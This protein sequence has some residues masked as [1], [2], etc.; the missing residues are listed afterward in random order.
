MLKFRDFAI[1]SKMG[2]LVLA[3]FCASQAHA[4]EYKLA[5]SLPATERQAVKN[6]LLKAQS[7][8]PET[9]QQ[10]LEEVTVKIEP[11]KG[12]DGRAIGVSS[13]RARSITL[14]PSIMPALLAGPEKS[15]LT[16][17]THKTAYQ[18]ALVT[19]LHETTHLYDYVNVHSQEEW[20][21]IRECDRTF[22]QSKDDRMR[23]R[24]PEC[25]F[26]ERMHT[27]LSANPYFLQIA[28]W[29]GMSDNGFSG[30]SPDAYELTDPKEYLAV[31]MEYFLLDSQYKCRRPGMYHFL[32]THFKHVPFA[33]VTCDQQLGY[34]VP[35]S[36]YKMAQMLNIDPA[37]VYQVHYLFAE[38]GEKVMSGWGHAM[39]RLV[40]CSPQRKEVGPDC[41]RDIESHLVLSF[42]AFVDSMSISTWAGLSGKYPSRLFILPM[43]QVID[44]YTKGEFRPLRSLPLKLSREQIT[45]VLTRSVEVHWSY[46]GK[47]YFVSNNCATEAFNLLQSSLLLPQIMFSEIKTPV[48]LYDLLIK[49][50]LADEN[51]L[52]DRQKAIQLGYYFDS[53]KERYNTTFA[54][55]KK[56]LPKMPAQNF[57]EYLN[58]SAARRAFMIRG[59]QAETP[60]RVQAVAA[61]YLLEI[62][63]ERRLQSA[64][65]SDLQSSLME[66]IN[67]ANKGEKRSNNAEGT[68]VDNY[69]ELSQL[70]AKASSFLPKNSGYGLPDK[71]ELAQAQAGIEQK[72]QHA[73]ETAAQTQKL[74]KELTSDELLKEADLIKA[75]IELLKKL[76]KGN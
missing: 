57:E 11:I 3:L 61:L 67:A 72:A 44:E 8:L 45:N 31:N 73:S 5:T 19:V 55:A 48:S 66:E 38:K 35:N 46:E 42:R 29:M 7:L 74:T 59:I 52:K 75:N 50:N 6:L 27:S 17:R 34:V 53:F 23:Q 10:A 64:M 16:G 14:A 56:A 2:L 49:K 22:E 1:R 30:R 18:E 24:A 70:F 37:R 28:G 9:L 54:V 15:A 26:Y 12:G 21:W 69:L 47:Y 65:L 41:L 62:A 32:S 4:L 63:A 60:N 68:I 25:Q 20:N 76:L 39:I 71:S 51:V 40:V 13:G 58:L 36:S 43:N 33:D